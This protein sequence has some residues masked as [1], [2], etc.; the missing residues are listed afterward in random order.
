[1]R[2]LIETVLLFGAPIATIFF[3]FSSMQ[4]RERAITISKL[5]CEN[6]GAQLLDQTVALKKIRL[7]RDKRGRIQFH[8][9]YNFDYSYD[10]Y[11]RQ[12]GSVTMLGPLSELIQLDPFE[13]TIENA[14]PNQI[15]TKF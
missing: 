15:Q 7:R 10:G 4:A 14:A 8:R 6:Y 1:M 13:S 3:W 5:T 11:D 9:T 2:E 12:Q